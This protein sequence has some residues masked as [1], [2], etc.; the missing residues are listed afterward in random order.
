[1]INFNLIWSLSSLATPHWIIF[2]IS[3]NMMGAFYHWTVYNYWRHQRLSIWFNISLAGHSWWL[4]KCRHSQCSG[5][6]YG[7]ANHTLQGSFVY[8]PIQWET[9]LQCN[10]VSHW[11]GAYTKWSLQCTLNSIGQTLTKVLPLLVSF[12]RDHFAYAPRQ[13]L[14]TYTKWSLVLYEIYGDSKVPSFPIHIVLQ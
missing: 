8:A 4:E 11:L 13:W 10:V 5:T 12:C 2:F 6:H 14:G 3:S 7:K 1:M 9:T